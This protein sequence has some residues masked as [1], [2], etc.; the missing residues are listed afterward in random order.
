MISRRAILFLAAAAAYGIPMY[1]QIP[2]GN[3]SASD[4]SVTGAVVMA[5]GETRIMSGSNI[6]TGQAV[7]LLRLANGGEVRICPHS[8]LV[9]T[10]SQSGNQLT[11][12][13]GTGAIETH[14]RLGSFADTILTPDFR[15]LLAGPGDFHFAVASDTRGDT[16]VRSL[17]SNTASVIVN[18]LLGE[19]VYQVGPGGQVLF[20]GGSIKAAENSTP[21]D[22]GC[23]PPPVKPQTETSG[24]APS[25]AGSPSA[26]PEPWPVTAP[27]PAAPVGEVHVSVD[28]PFVFRGIDPSAPPSPVVARLRLQ[29][30]PPL[31]FGALPVAPPTP[32]PE[33]EAK[34]EPG[35]KPAPKKGF[36]GRLG[37]LFA[38]LFH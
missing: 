34:R 32:P 22:C 5:A 23:P 14:F 21:P 26:K 11:L 30:L 15:I 18:E 38:A 27:P 19:G 4:A 9:V 8:S 2:V 37:S 12:A 31:F 33:P 35:G 20:H 10:A 28:A 13:V 24:Q 25:P 16:C 29:T 6:G 3:L 1:A 36:F 7:A 17:S